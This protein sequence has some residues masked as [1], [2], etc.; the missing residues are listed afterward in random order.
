MS[1]EDERWLSLV[2]SHGRRLYLTPGDTRA[3]AVLASRGAVYPRSN[4]LWR[5]ALGL[6]E[7]DV[8]VDVGCNYGEMLAE[9]VAP[10]GSRVLAYE[11]SSAV[12]PALRRTIG[13]LPF[14]VELR[15]VALS[16]RSG[17]AQFIVDETWSGRSSLEAGAAGESHR[18]RTET[19][20]LTTIDAELADWA[21]GSICMKIDVEGHDLRVLAG[22][23]QALRR[24]SAAVVMVEILH[25]PIEQILQ[26]ATEWRMYVADRETGALVR[27]P[28]H[29]TEAAS[30][31]LESRWIYEQD[32]LL[33][34][35]DV[36][37]DG[38]DDEE[39]ALA[40]FVRA[41]DAATTA[42]EI[43]ADEVSPAAALLEREID[44]MRRTLSWR[45]TAPL[46]AIRRAIGRD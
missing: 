32:A 20:E 26:L 17:T 24:A 35:G 41:V 8:I 37:P 33:C 19:V 12:L 3:E 39:G 25:L 27:L 21:G 14:L 4:A 38:L 15:E 22:A 28:A 44:A 43:A 23:M 42:R 1:D 7:W 2:G 10:R 9:V 36:S 18:V 46:R 40:A 6:R 45:I 31:L 5:A 11:P 13:E 34:H 16:D 29:G 30:A